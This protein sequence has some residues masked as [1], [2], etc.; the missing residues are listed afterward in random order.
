LVCTA[1][2]APAA[3]VVDAAVL[4]VGVLV[5]VDAALDVVLELLLLPQPAS[6]AIAAVAAAPRTRGRLNVAS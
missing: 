3:A 6:S 1:T 2:P 4:C 5:G